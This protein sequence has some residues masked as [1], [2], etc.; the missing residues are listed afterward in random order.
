M[1]LGK[2]EEVRQTE[3]TAEVVFKDNAVEITYEQNAPPY[4][5]WTQ[6]PADVPTEAAAFS[7]LWESLNSEVG[8]LKI[9]LHYLNCAMTRLTI[10][11]Q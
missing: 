9:E 2:F 4:I 5:S 11:M 3:N 6:K 1:I 8:Q 7:T 10:S